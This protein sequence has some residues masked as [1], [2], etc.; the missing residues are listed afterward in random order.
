MYKITAPPDAKALPE[1]RCT[2]AKANFLTWV[3]V[4]AFFTRFDPEKTMKGVIKA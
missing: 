2:K 3:F 1:T 4:G